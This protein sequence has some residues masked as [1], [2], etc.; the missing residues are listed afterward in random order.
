MKFI[1]GEAKK[2]ET[3]RP[4]HR[5]A[6]SGA[7]HHAENPS[8][9][10]ACVRSK[11]ASGCLGLCRCTVDTTRMTL[12]VVVRVALCVYTRGAS[13]LEGRNLQKGVKSAK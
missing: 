11:L 13:K 8:C 7:R 5:W 3:T 2:E 6:T 9:A 12:A 4:N 1:V 10:G